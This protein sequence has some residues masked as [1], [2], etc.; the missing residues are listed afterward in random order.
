MN[1][2]DI[3]NSILRKSLNYSKINPFLARN[4]NEVSDVPNVGVDSNAYLFYTN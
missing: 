1:Q 2:K 3:A 4:I